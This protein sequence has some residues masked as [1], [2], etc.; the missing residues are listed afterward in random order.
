M[1]RRRGRARGRRDERG[2]VAVE[3]ALVTPLLLLL[4]FGII[5]FGW[6]MNRDMLVGNASR[7]GARVASLGGTFAQTCTA[8]KTEL[9][10]AGVSVPSSCNTSNA[11]TTIYITGADASGAVIAST[12]ADYG[13]KVGSGS[14]AIVTVTYKYPWVTP[15]PSL[16]SGS[17]TKTITEVTQMVVE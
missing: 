3:F 6:M 17:S 4:V 13:T 15:M 10:Q 8:V 9:S 5:D 7:D 11:T 16:I 14:T 12:E 1:V 2:A